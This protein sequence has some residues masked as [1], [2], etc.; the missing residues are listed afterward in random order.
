M[1]PSPS[2]G[3]EGP[4][5]ARRLPSR[6][7]R[8]AGRRRG[9]ASIKEPGEECAGQRG[10]LR[11]YRLQNPRQEGGLRRLR[12]RRRPRALARLHIKDISRG[13]GPPRQ[14]HRCAIE[15]RVA[16]FVVF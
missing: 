7:P 1:A 16:V 8:Q 5:L 11:G 13:C 10:Q 14:L 15:Q 4:G 6:L 9:L 2:P 3:G 12:A